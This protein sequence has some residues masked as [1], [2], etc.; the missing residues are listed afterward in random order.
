[1]IDIN[2]GTTVP[3]IA[4]ETDGGTSTGMTSDQEAAVPERR[5]SFTLTRGRRGS[6]SNAFN[7]TK[8]IGIPG[9]NQEVPSDPFDTSLP[10]A[11]KSPSSPKVQIF[12]QALANLLVYTV[13]VK[14]RGINKKEVYSVEHMFSLSEKKTDKMLKDGSIYY[15]GAEDLEPANNGGNAAGGMLDLIKHAQT[16][17]VRTYPKGTRLKSTN[18]LPHRYW[19]AGAQLVAIN[20]QTSGKSPVSHL[21][22]YLLTSSIFRP[23]LYD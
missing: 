6:R 8:P 11:S 9:A 2:V 14:F 4:A 18:Y 19:A 12:S 3:I 7:Q 10:P 20:W 13:G 21:R 15:A 5:G 23:G 16:H 22:H 17:L 1:M